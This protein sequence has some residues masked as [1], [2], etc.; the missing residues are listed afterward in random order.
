MLL[1]QTSVV[2]VCSSP[3]SLQSGVHGSC[4]GVSAC[5]SC[6]ITTHALTAGDNKTGAAHVLYD[7][8]LSNR[9]V[10]LSAARKRRPANP[11]DFQVRRQPTGSLHWG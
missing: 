2:K 1:P 10:L 6:S 8:N 3:T 11:F 5:A 4:Q 7:L 9:G